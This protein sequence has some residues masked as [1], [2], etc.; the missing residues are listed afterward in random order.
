[1]IGV[2]IYEKKAKMAKNKD[3][4]FQVKKKCFICDAE[5]SA[6]DRSR[7][8]KTGFF[9]HIEEEHNLWNYIFYLIYLKNK[10]PESLNTIETTV[11]EQW[12]HN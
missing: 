5:R 10:E 3:W 2:L 7:N 1:M 11:L 9:K 8:D 12:E 4:E 6:V